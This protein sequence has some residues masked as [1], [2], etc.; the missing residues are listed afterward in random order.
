[1]TTA[2]ARS[3]RSSAGRVTRVGNAAEKLSA[4]V[5]NAREKFFRK[6]S[7]RQH[8]WDDSRNEREHR[9]GT[10]VDWLLLTRAYPKQSVERVLDANAFVVLTVSHVFAQD[11]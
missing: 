2:G 1:M 6:G 9:Q 5:G 8:R 7:H 4:Q 3:S 10:Q 11:Y